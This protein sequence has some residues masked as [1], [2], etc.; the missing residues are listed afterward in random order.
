[1]PWQSQCN[2]LDRILAS[3]ALTLITRERCLV[4]QDLEGEN[5][6]AA[7]RA[8]RHHFLPYLLSHQS[9]VLGP[10]RALK[11]GL[12]W[13]GG[14]GASHDSIITSLILKMLPLLLVGGRL[15]GRAQ[16]LGSEPARA[17]M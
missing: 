10:Q 4:S 5:I 6:P 12:L 8:K 7:C 16:V 9:P 15:E 3:W 1:M 17:Q 11:V 2:D 13:S 14:R